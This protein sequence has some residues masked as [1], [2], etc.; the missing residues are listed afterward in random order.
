MKKL[1]F[2]LPLIGSFLV[3]QES[4]PIQNSSKPGQITVQGCV[5]RSGGDYILMRQD[6]AMTYQLHATGK[7]K[8]SHYLGQQVQVTGEES[9]SMRTSS[10]PSARTGSASVALTIASIETIAK[11]CSAR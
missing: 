1:W 2:V 5:S 9:T 7:I 6:P 3:A 11:E 10:T 4:K 8:L